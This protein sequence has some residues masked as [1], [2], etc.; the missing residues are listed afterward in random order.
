MVVRGVV[1][2]KFVNK[3]VQ[4]QVST[5]AFA[6]EMFIKAHVKKKKDKEE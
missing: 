6:A 5:S 3:I 1:D 2:S 4:N